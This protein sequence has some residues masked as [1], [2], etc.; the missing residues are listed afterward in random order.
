MNYLNLICLSM[1]C[2]FSLHSQGADHHNVHQIANNEVQKPFA[3]ESL[4]NADLDLLDSNGTVVKFSSLRGKPVVIS[5]GYTGC[6]Y[7]CPL[8]ISKMKDLEVELDKKKSAVKP[9][10]VLISFDFEHDS[11]E[12]LKAYAEKRKLGREWSLY[13]AKSDKS[14]REIA[15][16]LGIKYKKLDGGGFDHSFIITVLDSEGVV[17]GQAVGADKDPKDLIKFLKN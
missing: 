5:M 14:P 13:T 12:V 2:V 3:D 10:F 9:H 6:A 16:L 17:K 8:I 1:V 11:P 15:N 4:Y 7:A